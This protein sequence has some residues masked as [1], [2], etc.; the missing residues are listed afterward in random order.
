MSTCVLR[1][2]LTVNQAY[3]IMTSTQNIYICKTS[4]SFSRVRITQEIKGLDDEKEGT[5]KLATPKDQEATIT[6]KW[7]GLRV[8][9]P[10]KRSGP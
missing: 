10:Y 7:E 9:I 5:Q 3:K 4:L 6:L 2:E 8:R 1:G